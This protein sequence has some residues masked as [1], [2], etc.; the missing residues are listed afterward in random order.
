M[1][2]AF[3]L[4]VALWLVYGW[5]LGEWPIIVANAVTLVLAATILVT[6][7]GRRVARARPA[8]TRALTRNRR[9]CPWPGRGQSCP[10]GCVPASSSAGRWPTARCWHCRWAPGWRSCSRRFQ[11][12]GSQHGVGDVRRGRSLPGLLTPAC[13]IASSSTRP[14]REP[15]FGM[16]TRSAVL[17]ALLKS[18]RTVQRIDAG[19]VDGPLP[20]IGREAHR[21][22]W[23]R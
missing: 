4:G 20:R 22:S 21:E 13:S 10:A 18:V 2:S 1:Y 14:Q 8:L 12:N 19:P 16:L 6:K 15:S 3:T 23:T 5:R 11:V 17:K 7:L 9:G